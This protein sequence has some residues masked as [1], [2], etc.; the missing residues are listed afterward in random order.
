MFP[1]TATQGSQHEEQRVQE[2]L[3]PIPGTNLSQAT[4]SECLLEEASA[5]QTIWRGAGPCATQDPA[6][7]VCGYLHKASF[8]Q[9]VWSRG[10]LCC[11]HVVT[12]S[13]NLT[14]DTG[15]AAYQKPVRFHV[16]SASAVSS[17]PKLPAWGCC[18]LRWAGHRTESVWKQTCPRH[19]APG[20]GGPAGA[21]G[22][23]TYPW[24]WWREIKE[25]GTGLGEEVVWPRSWFDF[26]GEPKISKPRSR[27]LLSRLNH[28][29][30]SR[31]LLKPGGEKAVFPQSLSR[32]ELCRNHL[33]HCSNES[34]WLWPG[35]PEHLWHV[36]T[37]LLLVLGSPPLVQQIINVPIEN[38]TQTQQFLLMFC[39]LNFFK[40]E[41]VFLMKCE[42]ITHTWQILPLANQRGCFLKCIIFQEYRINW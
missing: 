1:H 27:P 38:I 26:V 28:G 2:S 41:R 23:K 34:F 9:K 35:K 11:L 21:V 8:L 25:L 40:L 29:E 13:I 7:H 17:F 42:V 18:G 22:G 10:S 24:A 4:L 32:Q 16:A 5:K 31:S 36:S 14:S 6:L 37:L 3:L 30:I 19:W 33:L 20:W 15:L 39:M 12:L